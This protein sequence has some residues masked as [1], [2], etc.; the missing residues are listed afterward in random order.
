MNEHVFVTDVNVL[1]KLKYKL[2]SK[3]YRIKSLT[4]KEMVTVA[5]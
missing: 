2:L 4:Y 5:E 1:Q 3:K